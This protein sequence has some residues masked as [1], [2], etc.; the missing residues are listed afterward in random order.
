[1]KQFTKPTLLL[2]T[3]LAM[4]FS[5]VPATSHETGQ[6][7][8]APSMPMHGMGMGMGDT[9][10]WEHGAGYMHGSDHMYGQGYMHGPGMMR[11]H[12]KHMMQGYSMM[13]GPGMMGHQGMMYGPGMMGNMFGRFDSDNDGRM[14][15]GEMREGFASRMKEF[16]SDGDGS[17]TL[18]EFE[19]F[20]AAM[21]RNM[22][23]DHFQALDED[24]DGRITG[25]EMSAPADRMERLQ[26]MQ[27]RWRDNRMQ[28][29]QQRGMGNGHMMTDE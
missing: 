7:G 18:E 22:V 15:P 24:G 17:M 25:E 14:S 13:G 23:V 10:G 4:G 12:G 3:L 26:H 27:Q 20:H 11:D 8:S 28:G 29:S 21:I 1:M 2:T 16:D 5:A 9:H 6:Q 19:D